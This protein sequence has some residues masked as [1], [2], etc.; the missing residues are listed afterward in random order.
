MRRILWVSF[1]PLLLIGTACH[2]NQGDTIIVNQDC[3]LIRSDLLGQWNVTFTPV[4]ATL[5][6]CSDPTFDGDTVTVNSTTSIFNDMEV[7]ASAGNVGFQFHNGTA[8]Q[9]IFGNIET[10]SCNMLFAILDDE[11][12]YL[13]C[14]GTFDRPSGTLQGAC[15]STTVLKTPV[16]D[17]P[18][19]LADCDLTPI[20]HVTLAI[21]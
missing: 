2:G 13:Q 9:V 21:L 7:F 10:D 4:T 3:G 15:D 14:I 20:L 12:Q 11:G 5:S 6:S 8:P 17:P 1:L 18:I 19:I 16:V